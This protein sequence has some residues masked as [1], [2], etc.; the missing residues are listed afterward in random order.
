[1]A[2][3]DDLKLPTEIKIAINCDS[4]WDSLTILYKLLCLFCG[5]LDFM[6]YDKAHLHNFDTEP[7][8]LLRKLELYK[9]QKYPF[10][11]KTF[12][13]FKGDIVLWWS[14]NSSAIPELCYVACQLFGICVTTTSNTKVVAISHTEIL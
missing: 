14:Y 6:Q 8:C 2:S 9:Q 11:E 13:H 3:D 1:M 12:N 4:F 7:N 10:T 5:A